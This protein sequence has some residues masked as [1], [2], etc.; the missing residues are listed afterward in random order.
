MQSLDGGSITAY[1]SEGNPVNVQL[2]W[3]ETSSSGGNTSWQLF[4]Q[5][6]NATQPARQVA[7]QNAG[8]TFTFNS[9]G[10]LTSPTSSEP[11]FAESDRER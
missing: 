4:Y 2:R 11:D 5:T 7:W 9:S 10:Q 1:D 3:A 8:Q 6:S